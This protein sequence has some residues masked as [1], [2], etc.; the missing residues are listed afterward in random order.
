VNQ[1]QALACTCGHHLDDHTLT[2]VELTK[3]GDEQGRY[4]MIR[5]R[6]LCSGCDCNKFELIEPMVG[7]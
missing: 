6:Y 4:T 3:G 7:G 5:W 1:T 2:E